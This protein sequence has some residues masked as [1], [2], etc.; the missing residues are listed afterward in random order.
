M[1]LLLCRKGDSEA[2]AAAGKIYPLQLPVWIEVS[3]SFVKEEEV[4]VNMDS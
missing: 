2:S 3:A 1:P 4:D